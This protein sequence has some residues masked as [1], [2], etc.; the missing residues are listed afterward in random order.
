MGGG[1]TTSISLV[2]TLFTYYYLL[3]AVRVEA[4]IAPSPSFHYQK[5]PIPRHLTIM[6][7]E[8]LLES[9]LDACTICCKSDDFP[10][11]ANYPLATFIRTSDLVLTDSDENGVLLSVESPE[12]GR[13]MSAL[14]VI[15]LKEATDE[16]TRWS[17]TSATDKI[18]RKRAKKGEGGV[19]PMGGSWTNAAS[20][21]NEILVWSSK[22]TRYAGYGSDNH[23]VK[24]RGLINASAAIVVELIGNSDRV[25][26]YNKLSIGREDDLVLTTTTT[27]PTNDRTDNVSKEDEGT[28]PTV[29]S[30]EVLC[31]RLC[32]PG[33]AKV[34]SSKSQPPLTLK[35][36]EFKTLYY[37]RRLDAKTDGVELDSSGAPAYVTVGR[38]T[39][40]TST[41]TTDG[42]DKSCMR[43]EI[44]LAVNLVRG[45]TTTNGEE[46]CELTL[47]THAISPG[48]PTFIGKP[49]ALTSAENY[50]RDIRALF[51]E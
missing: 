45:I 14:V 29:H 5:F 38:S 18:L 48:I 8:M 25:R 28:I 26:E 6:A 17:P 30:L 3:V 1:S 13:I 42:S 4:L 12:A 22:C 16:T 9:S 27:A 37:A 24:A 44:L 41:G 40:E 43:C 33:L 35:P 39:W 20:D 46:W 34:M 23:I 2:F 47:I 11:T 31:P 51:E 32:V 21:R 10:S 50:I 19:A 36:L 7:S 15:A 49:L